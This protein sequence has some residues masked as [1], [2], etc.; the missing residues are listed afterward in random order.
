MLKNLKEPY[1]VGVASRIIGQL[2]SFVSVAVA[3]RYLDLEIFGTY[4]LAWAWVVIGNTFVF[5]GFYQ[6]LL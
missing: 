5:T 3:S 4:A 1:V 6:A 2:I